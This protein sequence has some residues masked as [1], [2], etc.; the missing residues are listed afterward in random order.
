M[1][2]C[3]NPG[4]PRALPSKIVDLVVIDRVVRLVYLWRDPQAPDSISQGERSRG[5]DTRF[6]RKGRRL[7]EGDTKHST[8]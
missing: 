3:G 8:V 1:S 2:S 6:Q 4:R 5:D 7:A